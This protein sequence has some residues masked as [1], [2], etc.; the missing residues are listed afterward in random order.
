VNATSRPRALLACMG[1]HAKN[2][3]RRRVV[4]DGRALLNSQFTLA[5]LHFALQRGAASPLEN[6]RGTNPQTYSAAAFID[7]PLNP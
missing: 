5:T 4:H 1:E 3:S 2:T 6:V 7:E